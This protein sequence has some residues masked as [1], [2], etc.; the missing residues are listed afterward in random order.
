MSDLNVPAR[1]VTP[2]NVPAA[3]PLP[4]APGG[5]DDLARTIFDRYP[6]YAY[7]LAIPEVRDLLIQAVTPGTEFSP[8]AFAAALYATNW[9]RST[10]ASVREWD[11]RIGQDPASAAG[12]VRGR[13]AEIRDIAGQAGLALSTQQAE[14]FAEQTLRFGISTSSAEFRDGLALL[15]P[16]FDQAGGQAPAGQF[17]VYYAQVKKLAR[18]Y[19]MPLSDRDAWSLAK[20]AFSGDLSLDG[21]AVTWAQQASG[22]NPALQA[23]IESGLT[24]AQWLSPLRNAVAAELEVSA[25]DVDP[26]DPQWSALLGVD[27]GKGGTRAMTFS[28]AQTF[29]RKRPEWQKTRRA[30]DEASSLAKELLETFGKIA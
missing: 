4:A 29:A 8:D 12:D 27:D 28:E 21:L 18:D 5:S 20:Q 15:I 13:V 9:W 26:M 1:P 19:L 24:P 7:L 11:A 30:N 16:G 10:Q 14:Q 23:A 3:A 6:A 25:D 22:R 17:G 2:V